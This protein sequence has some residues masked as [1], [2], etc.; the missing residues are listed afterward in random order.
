MDS[1]LRPYRCKFPVEQ[2]EE[3]RFSS[4]ACLLRHEREAHGEHTH[5]MNP[6]LCKFPDC[7]RAREGNGFPRRWN[8]RDH[9]KRVHQYEEVNA[10]TKK[11]LSSQS[12]PR[13]KKVS[14]GPTSVPMRRSGSST[15]SKAHA[16]VGA[17]THI[18]TYGPISRTRYDAS[19]V[20]TMPTQDYNAIMS[21]PVSMSQVQYSPPVAISR[22]SRVSP[23]YPGVYR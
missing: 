17:A 18:P 13:R 22:I 21:Q 14:N 1:H 16:I 8:Q 7:D 11:S 15:V 23:P 3:L 5:G 19:S 10:P 6:Y 9:M 20:Y 12:Q 4:N 2:C